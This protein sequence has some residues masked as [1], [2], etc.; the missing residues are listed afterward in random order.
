MRSIRFKAE[1]FAFRLVIAA[2]IC[3]VPLG[4]GRAAGGRPAQHRQHDVVG[5]G[6]SV[7]ARRL[8]RLVPEVAVRVR[9]LGDVAVLPR[10]ELPAGVDDAGVLLKARFEPL[11]RQRHRGDLIADEGRR[12]AAAAAGDARAPARRRRSRRAE[13]PVPPP[14]PPRPRHL[15]RGAA[16]RRR[17]RRRR[18]R[19]ARG[20]SAPPVPAW[21]M[22]P[23]PLVPRRAAGGSACTGVAAA[24]DSAGAGIPTAAPGF[25]SRARSGGAARATGGARRTATRAPGRAGRDEH[26]TAEEEDRRHAARDARGPSCHRRVECPD[27]RLLWHSR[28]ARPHLTNDADR[29]T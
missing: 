29:G 20:T 4:L 10:L 28:T 27:R 1:Y 21:P 2:V 22:P 24:G 19:R 12:R 17:P 13:P 15:R 25:P 8:D 7:R 5:V 11:A 9:P 6:R 16:R 3:V 18:R 14:A 23:R 26:E